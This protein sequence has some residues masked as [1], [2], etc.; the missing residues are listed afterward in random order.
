MIDTS[1]QTWNENLHLESGEESNL[2]AI[3]IADEPTNGDTITLNWQDFFVKSFTSFITL[4]EYYL[5]SFI[6]KSFLA[7]N[8]SIEDQSASGYSTGF[9]SITFFAVL[10][11]NFD[12]LGVYVP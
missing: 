11:G 4:S 10:F 9:Y 1:F 2:I 7:A 6:L 8:A 3:P 12:A 5:C